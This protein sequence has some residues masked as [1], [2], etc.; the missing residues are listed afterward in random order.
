MSD[1]QHLSPRINAARMA[2]FVGKE[3][4]LVGRVLSMDSTRMT[5]EA[6]DGGQVIVTNIANADI[7]NSFVE[8]VGKVTNSTTIHMHACINMGNDLDTKLVNDTIELIHDSR[9]YSKIFS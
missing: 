6:C 3:A 5:I 7:E 2:D 9:Y 1:A 8:V 4:R